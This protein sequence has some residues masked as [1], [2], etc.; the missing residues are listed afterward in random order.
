MSKYTSAKKQLLPRERREN[1]RSKF[2][3][4]MTVK[5]VYEEFRSQGYNVVFSPDGNGDCQFSA[6]AHHLASIGV[7]LGKDNTRRNL[8]ISGTK[9]ELH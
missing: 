9:S 1:A 6:I 3:I 2:Y 5:D 7:S 4:P 8:S